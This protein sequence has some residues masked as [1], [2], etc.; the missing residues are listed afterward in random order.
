[1]KAVHR[2]SGFTL[3]E[4]MIVV[5]IIG[6]IAAIAYPSYL[7]YVKSARRSDAQSS[8]MGLA[9]AME[10]HRTA[11]NTYEGAAVGPLPSAPANYADTSPADGGAAYY[12]LTIEAASPTSYEIKADPIN[13]QDGDGFLTLKN[14][15]A[16]GWDKDDSGVATG[17]DENTWR[18]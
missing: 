5:A 17:A 15:G 2:S 11:N 6:I 10:R 9:S 16:R 4:L 18:K 3:I 1:M 8:L 13:A 12:G 14:T 7:E